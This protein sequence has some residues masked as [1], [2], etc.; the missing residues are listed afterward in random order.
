MSHNKPGG[1]VKTRS[2]YHQA[3]KLR[4]LLSES[5]SAIERDIVRYLELHGCLV[6]PTHGP[7]NRPVVEGIPDLLVYK[8]WDTNRLSTPPSPLWIEV[9]TRTGQLSPSQAEMHAQL[10]ERGARVIVARCVEDVEDAV[11]GRCR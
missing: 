1:K 3:T 11:F 10:T 7:R 9:K 8:R 2:G 5:E 6:I 4:A